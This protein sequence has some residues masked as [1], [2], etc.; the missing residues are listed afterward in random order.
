MLITRNHWFALLLILIIQTTHAQNNPITVVTDVGHTLENYTVSPDG[1]YLLTQCE[2][3]VALWNLCTMQTINVLSFSGSKSVLFGPGNPLIAYVETSFDKYEGYNML[4]GEFMGIKSKKDLIPETHSNEKYLFMKRKETGIIDIYYRSTGRLVNTLDSKP[5]PSLGKIDLTKDD[6]LLL[7]TGMHPQIWNLRKARLENKLPFAEYILAQ[8]PSI[9]V[10]RQQIPIMKGA[11]TNGMWR[12]WCKGCFTDDGNI[13]LG[14]FND[15]TTWSCEGKLLNVQ[16]TEGWPVLDWVDYEGKRYVATWQGGLQTGLISDKILRSANNPEHMN[17]I[18]PVLS[19]KM[20]YYSSNAEYLLY[21]N[22]KHP[23]LLYKHRWYSAFVNCDVSSDGRNLLIAGEYGNLKEI[24]VADNRNWFDYLSNDILR[25]SRVNAVRFLQGESH[26]VGGCSDGVV[27]LWQHRDPYP[28]WSVA[29]HRGQVMDIMPTHLGMRFVTSGSDGWCRIYDWEERKELMAMYSPEGTEDYLFLTPDNYYKGTKGTFSDIHFA[30]GTETFGFDQFDLQFNRP[31]IILER[32]GGEKKEI[33]MM[34]KAWLKRVKRMGFIPEQ[35]SAELHVPECQI[36]DSEEIPLDVTERKLKLHLTAKDSRYNLSR[37]MLYLNGVPMLG[38]NGFDISAKKKS[39]YSM[40]YELELTSCHNEITFSCIN[41]KGAE[42]N[43]RTVTVYYTPE[44]NQ[45]PDLYLVAIGV[46][47]YAQEGFNLRYAAKDAQ[48]FTHLMSTTLHDKFAHVH[49]LC[50][51]D[52]EVTI[53]SLNKVVPFI[54]QSKREDAVMLFYAGHGL[55]DQQADYF[56]STYDID[57]NEP[58][59]RGIPF[60]RTEDWFENV[61]ALNRCYF[62]DACHSGELDKDDLLAEA[63]VVVP[64]GK[65]VFRNASNKQHIA[66]QGVRQVNTLLE[67]LFVETRWGI[68]ATVMSSA[69]G[70]EA[71]IEGDEWKNGLFTWCLRKGMNDP[72]AD[73]NGNGELTMGELTQYLRDEVYRLSEGRQRPTL[74][75]GKNSMTDFLLR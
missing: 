32:L 56:L 30:K 39:Q 55:L 7:L 35:L 15:I 67:E 33:D 36:V 23:G 63:Q 8:H 66:G 37:I 59:Q 46:S 10:K 27:A 6:S 75:S 52:A 49:T 64:E 51:T 26:F 11:N 31:D 28:I 74:R 17:F 65:M 61:A 12:Q 50:L 18:S 19:D 42:S 69:G 44:T 5:M 34:H 45:L 54:Q 3:S 72:K 13:L 9:T 58:S 60:E 57:F 43:R 68:G 53:E 70:L 48:D 41:E 16:E 14:G 4:T 25:H 21:G 47:Q 29:A 20:S 24:S 2:G 1:N 40:E 62:I 71:A 73:I 22:I 38:R